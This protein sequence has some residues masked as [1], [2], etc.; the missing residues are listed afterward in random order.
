MYD[1]IWCSHEQ[2]QEPETDLEELVV[3][4]TKEQ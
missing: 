4:M 1:L 2:G 3:V